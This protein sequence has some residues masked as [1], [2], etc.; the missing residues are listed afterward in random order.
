MRTWELGHGPVFICGVRF[1]ED[2]PA[3]LGDHIRNLPIACQ[4]VYLRLSL[5]VPL[6]VHLLHIGY[7]PLN[8][9]SRGKREN[10]RIFRPNVSLTL[11]RVEE[12][13]FRGLRS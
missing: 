2:L 1:E 4:I 9:L 13:E 7:T 10:M 5:L 8:C 6:P 12:D 3:G 11:L